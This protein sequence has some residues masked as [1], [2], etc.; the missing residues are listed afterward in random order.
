MS[1]VMCRTP[2]FSSTFMPPMGT[3]AEW[4]PSTGQ[5]KRTIL[6]TV[7]G[8]SASV[9]TSQALASPGVDLGVNHFHCAC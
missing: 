6:A 3:Q 8:G 4:P 2:A 1:S 7:A 5:W 9:K